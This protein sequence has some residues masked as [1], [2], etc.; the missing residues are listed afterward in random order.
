MNYVTAAYFLLCKR[1]ELEQ[2]NE[3]QSSVKNKE[4][5]YSDDDW[6]IDKVT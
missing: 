1:K 4:Y 6:R 5:D 2:L 3:K